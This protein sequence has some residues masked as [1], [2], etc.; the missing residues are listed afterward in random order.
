MIFL[1]HLPI[2]TGNVKIIPMNTRK[3]INRYPCRFLV[4]GKV[5]YRVGILA[6]CLQSVPWCRKL[7]TG[8]LSRGRKVDSSLTLTCDMTS[9]RDT[10]QPSIRFRRLAVDTRSFGGRLQAANRLRFVTSCSSEL[11]EGW[12]SS[13]PVSSHLKPRVLLWWADVEIR[14]AVGNQCSQLTFS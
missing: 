9:L 5:Q 3:F 14:A 2:L 7:V 12:T 4:I 13:H 6:H 8:W 1:V 10:V 11:E